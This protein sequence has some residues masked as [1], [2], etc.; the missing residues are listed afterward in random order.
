MTDPTR[1]GAFDAPDAQAGG[2]QTAPNQEN[3]AGDGPASD[4]VT[5]AS[6]GRQ[7]PV[8]LSRCRCGCWLLGNPGNL[9][10]GAYARTKPTDVL[11]TA[12]ELMTGLLVD[13]GGADEMSTLQRSVAANLRDCVILLALNKRTIV[14]KGVDDP[15]GRRAHDRY[16]A[17][18]DRF[19]RLAAVLGVDRK[20]KNVGS[21][22]AQEYIRR[23]DEGRTE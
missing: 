18:L 6:C 10:H 7:N 13:Q 14:E 17:A 20:A 12:D 15:A 1:T 21:L 8:G 3:G 23:L 22:T 4:T 16:L 5:C 9:K 19:L 11:M 2:Q